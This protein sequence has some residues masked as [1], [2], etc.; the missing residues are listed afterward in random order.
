M[1]VGDASRARQAIGWRYELPFES[2]VREMVERD[3]ERM[4]S[5]PE[6]LLHIG[7]EAS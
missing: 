3:L 2:L 6:E 1:L 5:A 4:R 7:V